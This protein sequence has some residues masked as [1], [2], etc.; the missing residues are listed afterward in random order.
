M[1]IYGIF[2]FTIQ[3][4]RADILNYILFLLNAHSATMK[5]FNS[6]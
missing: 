4:L 1:K 2:Y 3:R 6:I 5:E